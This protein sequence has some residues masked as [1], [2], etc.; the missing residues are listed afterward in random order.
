MPT[1]WVHSGEIAGG[2]DCSLAH[3][4]HALG[5]GLFSVPNKSDDQGE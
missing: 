3:L 5:S 2:K 4:S 1:G